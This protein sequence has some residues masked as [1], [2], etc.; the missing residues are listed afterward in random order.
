MSCFQ[1][2]LQRARKAKR[3][4]PHSAVIS[5]PAA[6]HDDR[7]PSV[8]VT[9]KPDGQVMMYCHSR[10]CDFASMVAGLGMQM[11]EFFSER[12]F[13]GDFRPPQRRDTPAADILA[14]TADE[15]QVA[16]LIVSDFHDWL[17]SKGERGDW[18]SFDNAQRL[19][20][21]LE[22]IN[23]AASE[24]TARKTDWERE[25]DE[26]LQAAQ[27]TPQELEDIDFLRDHGVSLKRQQKEVA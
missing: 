27:L 22:R 14:A 10:R 4:G 17:L 13:T 19:A 5:C 2:V 23:A 7:H 1:E 26:I 16:Y 11:H 3:T 20:H 21:A 24:A 9:E 12:P 15:I 25:R 18:P 6:G 8:S